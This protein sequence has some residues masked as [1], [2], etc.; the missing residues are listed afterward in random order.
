MSHQHIQTLL[1]VSL[2][3]PRHA[4]LPHLGQLLAA[5]RLVD[6]LSSSE[7]EGRDVVLDELEEV[8]VA[9]EEVGEESEVPLSES[10][11]YLVD[12]R[13]ARTG[14]GLVPGLERRYGRRELFA[15]E[16]RQSLVSSR[17][18]L[19]VGRSRCGGLLVCPRD[20]A[21]VRG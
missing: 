12:E 21:S 14:E 9:L 18:G 3:E 1:D 16:G 15:R 4:V 20:D 11:G 5:E 10:A 2:D 8:V 7:M 17:G 6:Q 19:T 13:L